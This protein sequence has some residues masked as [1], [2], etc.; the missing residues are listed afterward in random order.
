ML[1]GMINKLLNPHRSLVA[2]GLLAAWCLTGRAQ[3]IT[4]VWEYLINNLPAPL[5]I[6]TNTLN[7]WTTDLENGDGVSVMDCIGPMRRYDANRLL[8]G[9]RENGIDETVAHDTNLANAYP[10]RSLIWINPTNGQPMGLALTMG[11][12]PVPLDTNIVAA[13][14]VPGSYYWSFDVSDDGYI[15]SGYKNQILRYA[16]NGSGG[17]SPTPTV[18]Y[19]LDNATALA[20]GV[21]QG[22]WTGFRWAHIRV[23]G[24][25]VNTKVLAGG[26]GARGVWLLT[27]T[28]GSTFT[29]GAHMNGGFGNAAG[30]ISNFIPNPTGSDPDELA[31]YGGSYPGNSSGADSTLYKARAVPPYTDA[32][33]PF[34]GDGS[35]AAK[36]DANTHNLTRYL[37]LF[38][39]SCDAHPDVDFV[40]NYSTPPYNPTAV[41]GDKP[42]WLAIHNRTNGDFIASYQICVSGAAEYLPDDQS[43]LF[44]GCL[45]SVSLYPLPDGTS[46]ILWTSEI[47]GY[48]RYVVGSPRYNKSLAM[49]K[50]IKPLWEQLQGQPGLKLPILTTNVQ[51]GSVPNNNTATMHVLTGLKRYDSNRLLLGIRDNGIN[52]TVAHNTNL[53]NQYPDRSLQW[54]DSETG[55]PLGTALTVSYAG[56]P[57]LTANNLQ[58]MAFGVADDGVVYVGVGNTIRRYAP[59]G[60]GFA[61]PTTAF[62]APPIVGDSANMLFA[63]FRITGG[64]PDTILLVG[65]KDWFGD[66]EWKL[67][68][69]D[70]LNFTT[71]NDLGYL[72]YPGFA[73]GGGNSSIVPDPANTGDNLL[74][75]TGYPSTS[76]G[77]DSTMKRRRQAGGTGGFLSEGFA[78]EQV[79]GNSITNSTDVIYRTLFL[80][81]VQTL[82]GLAYV[83][84]DST[85]SYNT[86]PTSINGNDSTVQNALKGSSPNPM[87][88]QPGWLAVHDLQTGEVL[89]LHKLPV[90]EALNVVGSG[91]TAPHAD[92]SMGYFQDLIP[93]GGVEMYAVRSGTGDTVGAEVLWWS[94]TYGYGRYYID[95]APQANHLRTTRVPTGMKLEWTGGGVLQSATSVEG[96]Y[97]DE[98]G[99]CSGYAYTGPATK[100]FRLRLQ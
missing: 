33:N 6:L 64:G 87:P 45:G 4:P 41:G 78:P 62:T 81:D 77:T 71:N 44:I 14:G 18:V 75:D 84:A 25:G 47:Y 1:I 74:F 90:T 48:G 98:I 26:I 54:I 53:A 58:N 94:A 20:N 65:N 15:Y 68:T 100:F 12:T 36:P 61:A 72:P 29:A 88:Y 83:V 27:T 69:T 86:F 49:S 5:P 85:P 31:F 7:G 73:F 30:N 79:S 23:R 66:G 21:S 99:L 34:I 50:P 2:V 39:G 38:Q 55:A 32:A 80:T 76:N 42:A 89:G 16:P 28:D 11:L 13:G 22:Q 60:N 82:P 46:E 19:T 17:I 57:D 8:L 70:G 37:A 35:F 96:P 9:I 56:A 40:V 10:D 97:T 59:S 51:T 52:E 93:Q 24:S 43:P 63:N 95:T 3:P 91:P 67:T 92:M